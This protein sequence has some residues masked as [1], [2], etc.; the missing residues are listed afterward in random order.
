MNTDPSQ[1]AAEIVAKIVQIISIIGLLIACLTIMLVVLMIMYNNVGSIGDCKT[2]NVDNKINSVDILDIAEGNPSH[3]IDTGR[4]VKS[5]L[6]FK[7]TIDYNRL[8]IKPQKY[9]A[10][11]KIDP[12]FAEP[13]VFLARYDDRNNQPY[14]PDWT[15]VSTSN[16]SA[17]ENRIVNL[18]N[19]QSRSLI[20]V[21][22]ADVIS[23]RQIDYN[24]FYDSNMSSIS[25]DILPHI[26]NAYMDLSSLVTSSGGIDNCIVM[27]KDT[28]SICSQGNCNASAM[29]SYAYMG[30]ANS[31]SLSCGIAKCQEIS[32]SNTSSCALENTLGLTITLGNEIKKTPYNPFI[33]IGTDTSPNLVYYIYSNQD[34]YLNF[35]YGFDILGTISNPSGNNNWQMIGDVYTNYPNISSITSNNFL[36]DISNFDIRHFFAGRYF[37]AIEVG[38]ATGDA[39]QEKLSN[40]SITYAIKDDQGVIVET[41]N[42]AS[43]AGGRNAGSTGSISYTIAHPHDDIGGNLVITTEAYSE[44]VGISNILNSRLIKPLKTQIQALSKTLY[45]TIVTDSTFQLIIRSMMVISLILYTMSF[46]LGF[47]EIKSKDLLIFTVKL[48]IVSQ[49]TT[50]DS[51]NF[52]NEYLFKV[53]LE[54]TDFLMSTVSGSVISLNNPFGFIDPILSKYFNSD[55]WLIIATYLA[56]WPLGFVIP[57]LLIAIGIFMFTISLLEMVV[58]YLIAFWGLCILI[59]LAPIFILFLLFNKTRS[60]FDGWINVMLGYV[61]KPTFALIFILFVDSIATDI[62]DDSLAICKEC[63]LNLHFN[64]SK[65]VGLDFLSI[66]TIPGICINAYIPRPLNILGIFRMTLVF[67]IIMQLMRNAIALSTEMA[68]RLTE[69][70][71]SGGGSASSAAAFMDQGSQYAAYGAGMGA[72]GATSAGSAAGSRMKSLGGRLTTS[73]KNDDNVSN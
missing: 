9:R 21:K 54:S 50:A 30:I 65:E 61:L 6:F 28:G 1:I 20:P 13:I 23:I 7:A 46:L 17:F 12:R 44:D 3:T 70:A 39:F 45:I 2:F 34:N 18:L 29:M 56:F 11:V 67:Y 49:L 37:L 27:T 53:F 25:G 66:F 32:S 33:N 48:I 69:G 60:L 22:N 16:S 42:A 26:E 58:S 62:L 43:L 10:I 52:F 40:I 31:P 15:N 51:W 71:V 38:S 36:S 55:L 63:I 14:I 35:G 47:I 73:S 24:E 4:I 19:Y 72:R 68:N 8:F 41:G 5:G 59:S 64:L 57:G